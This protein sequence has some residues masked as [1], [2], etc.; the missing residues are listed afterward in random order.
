MDSIII[1]PKDK[2]DLKFFVE[3]AERLGA[4][5]KTLDQFQDEQLLNRMIENLKHFTC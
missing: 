4:K 1:Q 2:A 3:L 5:F